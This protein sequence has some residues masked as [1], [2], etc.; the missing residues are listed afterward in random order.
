MSDFKLTKKQQTKIKKTLAKKNLSTRDHYDLGVMH[1]EIGD[2]AKAHKH[3]NQAIALDDKNGEAY[4]AR[5]YLHLC[6]EK[7][8][9]AIRDAQQALKRN[10]NLSTDN[11]FFARKLLDFHLQIE[12]QDELIH[13]AQINLAS[14]YNDR[15]VIHTKIGNLEAALKDLN[16]ALTYHPDFAHA[17]NNR[18]FVKL[19]LGELDEALADVVKA[20]D[21][22][23]LLDPAN[24]IAIQQLRNA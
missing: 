8:E 11:I 18:A 6:E 3:L 5:G 10:P 19:N 14:H 4:H 23:P 9:L 12:E 7:Y 22:D 24:L 15:A 13:D 17:Y 20:L 21:L 1:L 2:A 16:T